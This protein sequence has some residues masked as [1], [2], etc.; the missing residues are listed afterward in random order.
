MKKVIVKNV[1]REF[2]FLMAALTLSI[3]R[4]GLAFSTKTP[5]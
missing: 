1:I 4:H 2:I 5:I 3:G